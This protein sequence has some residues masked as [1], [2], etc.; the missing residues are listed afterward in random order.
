MVS[1]TVYLFD[2]LL[3]LLLRDS[4]GNLDGPLIPFYLCE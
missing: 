3:F 1:I 4:F 2:E